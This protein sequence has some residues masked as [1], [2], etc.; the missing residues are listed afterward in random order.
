MS[1]RK[2]TL[3]HT[4]SKL[5]RVLPCRV[6]GMTSASLWAG[7]SALPLPSCV[8]VCCLPPLSGP[9]VPHLKWQQQ[10]LALAARGGRRCGRRGS[11]ARGPGSRE[12]AQAR[13]GAGTL[14]SSVREGLPLIGFLSV[15]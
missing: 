5:R 6:V 15:F 11:A 3:K 1:G 4:L 10:R 2:H 7:L 12:H 8:T 14:C 13:G 9:Q